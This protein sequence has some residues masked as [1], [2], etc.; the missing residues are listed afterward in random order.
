MDAIYCGWFVD[1]RTR[2]YFISFRAMLENIR[3]NGCRHF[4]GLP[5]TRLFHAEATQFLVG[6]YKIF[7]NPVAVYICSIFS[8][9]F[10]ILTFLL[11][12]TG[13]RW[14]WR[15]VSLWKVHS[16]VFTRNFYEKLQFDYKLSWFLKKLKKW[17]IFLGM[18][19]HIMI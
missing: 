5:F 7:Q 18:L 3:A 12:G 8:S 1:P 14:I 13:R 15:E 16:N 9:H 2:F 17:N 6:K 11:E 10:L 4:V 19:F